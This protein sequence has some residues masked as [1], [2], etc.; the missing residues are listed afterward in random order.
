MILQGQEA[1]LQKRLVSY[2]IVKEWSLEITEGSMVL[3]QEER[4][5]YLEVTFTSS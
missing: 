5:E 2:A 3:T 4:P 1:W